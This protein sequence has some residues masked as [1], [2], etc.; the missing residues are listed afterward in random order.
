MFIISRLPN[1]YMMCTKLQHITRAFSSPVANSATPEAVF[2]IVFPSNQFA[3]VFPPKL[4][5]THSEFLH[6]CRR[7]PWRRRRRSRWP[8]ERCSTRRGA[9]PGARMRLQNKTRPHRM[10]RARRKHRRRG[11]ANPTHE[12]RGPKRHSYVH[13]AAQMQPE[14]PL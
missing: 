10:A 8:T 14:S 12:H 5:P 4:D 3:V 7:Y 6:L 13:I 1:V 11:C 2:A 9:A